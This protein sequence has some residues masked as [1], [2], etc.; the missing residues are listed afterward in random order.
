MQPGTTNTHTH[1]ATQTRLTHNT[2]VAVVLWVCQLVVAVGHVHARPPGWQRR[3]VGAGC[4][5]QPL[6]VG[7][8]GLCVGGLV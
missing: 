4:V 5:C 2:P 1:T 8:L 3:H 7:P 6:V